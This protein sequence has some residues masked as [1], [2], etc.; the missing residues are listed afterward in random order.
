[1]RRNW[2][3]LI[4]EALLGLSLLLVL[5]LLAPGEQ[6]AGALQQLLLPLADLDRVDGVVGGDLLD[7]LAA[8]DRLHGDPG[9]E[10]GTVGAALAHRWEPPF[11][12]GAPP[13]RLTMGAVQESQTTSHLDV[14][15]DHRTR[16]K[17]WCIS[18][19]TNPF[20]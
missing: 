11:R 19:F 3:G 1:L 12:G 14:L 20:R 2:S 5:A 6:L 16:S 9:L 8:T 4:Q 18:H 17:Q 10:L 13:Q 15:M 7:R